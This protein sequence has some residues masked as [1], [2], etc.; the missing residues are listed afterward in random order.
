MTNTEQGLQTWPRYLQSIMDYVRKPERIVVGLLSGTSA[1]G[2]S[3]VLVRIRGSGGDTRAEVLACDTIP[4]PAPLDKRIFD[5]FA[6]ET[7]TVD[8][9]AQAD[10]EIGRAFA[11]SARRITESGGLTL[12]DVD[13]IASVGQITYQVIEGQRDE[14]RWLGDKAITGFLVLGAGSVIAELTGVTT[15]SN[16]HQRDIAAGGIGV[17]GLT[18]ADWALCRDAKRGRSI[19]NIGGIA[20]PT[21]IPAGATMN[22]VFSFDSGPGN[23]IIDGLMFQMTN[24]EKA[25]DEDGRFAA[26][27]TVHK[28]LL[29]ELMQHPFL[30]VK[31]PRGAARQLYGHGY[32]ADLR[33]KGHALGLQDRDI[34]ATVTAF[35]AES[36]ALAYREFI[37]PRA[38]VDE[39]FLA[40]GGAH[41][42]TLHQ[43]ISQ[44][45]APIPVG[46]LDD[47]GYPVDSRE[48]LATAVIGNETI[49]GG[50][51]NNPGATGAARRVIVGD[52]SPS[53]ANP[54]I[55]LAVRS[56]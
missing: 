29:A 34:A 23:M 19:H 33:K 24:G 9:I 18:F 41:N 39:V 50:T 27:G 28:G 32:T 5:L 49:M 22:D 43:M 2:V 6:R 52:I 31:P 37:F 10:N 56:S 14:H 12:K 46:V 11:D 54:E 8:R 35:T 20:N 38:R 4:Y 30:R 1:D 53:G 47:I 21:V 51:G 7:A 45:L 25:Y 42:K 3:A 44:A 16:I 26:T 55:A 48:V 17:P 15:V 40:G 36:M 13:L